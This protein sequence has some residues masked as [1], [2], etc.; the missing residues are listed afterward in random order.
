MYHYWYN[1]WLDHHIP[2]NP[3]TLIELIKQVDLCRKSFN[4][5]KPAPV[6]VH[7]SAGI[8]RTGC[9]IAISLGMIQIDSD[10]MVDVTRIVSHMRQER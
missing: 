10:K 7:C 1:T 5:Y 3:N 2:D 8:G 6:L 9:F 4:D